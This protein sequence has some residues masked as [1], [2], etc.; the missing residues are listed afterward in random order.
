MQPSS[1][2]ESPY[3]VRR[4]AEA[5]LAACRDLIRQGSRSFYNAS[6]LLPRAVRDPAYALYAFCRL[7]DDAIDD[8]ETGQVD[9]ALDRL[10]ER[11][12]LAYAGRPID[13]ASDRAF[14]HVIA[15]FGVPRALPEALLEGFAWDAEGRR[16]ESIDDL[17]AYGARVAGAVGAMMAVLMGARDAPTLARATDLGCAMQLTNIA[18]DVGE[19]ARA[20]RVYLP[21]LWME[22]AGLDPEAWLAAPRFDD[23]LAHVISRLLSAADVLY[24]RAGAGIAGLPAACRPSIQAARTIYA[25]IGR[26]VERRGRDSVSQRA[27]VGRSRKVSLLGQALMASHRKDQ[28][29]NL[30]ALPQTQ[31]LVDAVVSAPQ[32]TGPIPS[33]SVDEQVGWVVDL[34]TR[35]ERVDRERPASGD[36]LGSPVGAD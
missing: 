35:L 25:E 6:L 22:E 17:N 24:A 31:F 12:E 33:R 13:R 26:E 10:R 29:L 36:P 7:A 16:Y 5:D 32:P 11:L 4:R 27:V 34:F 20:G 2:P 8:A 28:A 15:S 9:A 19:D 30:P 14:A 23:R 1:P 3:L 21:L 18:R